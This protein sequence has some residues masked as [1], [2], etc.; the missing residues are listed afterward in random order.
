MVTQFCSKTILLIIICKFF[1]QIVQ[2][3]LIRFN[4]LRKIMQQNI[5]ECFYRISVKALIL[6]GEKRFLLIKELGGKWEFPGGGLDFGE[7][8]RDGLSREIAEEMGLDVTFVADVP[9]CF[10][11][12][13]KEN[14][15]WSANIIYVTK[16]KDLDFTPSDECVEVRFFTKEEALRENLFSN[17]ADFVTMYDSENY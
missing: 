2:C 16:V 5:S 4:L 10:Q 3:F 6:D 13:Q 17:V 9:S 8:A 14:G 7:S 15:Q 11:T 12:F 1:G